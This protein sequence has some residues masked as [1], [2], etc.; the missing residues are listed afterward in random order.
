MVGNVKTAD[1]GIGIL[2][3]ATGGFILLTKLSWSQM[4]AAF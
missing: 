1:G 4:S 3:E 2:A